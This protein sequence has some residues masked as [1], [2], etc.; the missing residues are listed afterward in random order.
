M[1]EGLV[2]EKE[3]ERH[4]EVNE[5]E[6]AIVKRPIKASNKKTLKQRRKERLAKRAVSRSL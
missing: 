5:D 3:T 2:P 6:V 4:E 1:L